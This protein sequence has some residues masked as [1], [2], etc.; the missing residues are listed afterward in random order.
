[1]SPRTDLDAAPGAAR[2]TTGVA[3]IGDLVEVAGFGLAGAVVCGAVTAEEV[4]AA[5]AGLPPDIG[6]VIL[7]AN[8]AE[9][10]AGQDTGGRLTVAMP[11]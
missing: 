1:M 6:I 8:A 7:D 3:A 10:L 11:R 9:H 4:R 5:W 2:T